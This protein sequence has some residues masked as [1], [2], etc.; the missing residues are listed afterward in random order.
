MTLIAQNIIGAWLEKAFQDHSF[1]L[2]GLKLEPLLEPLHN[3]PLNIIASCGPCAATKGRVVIDNIVFIEA[4]SERSRRECSD[5]F[6]ARIR[7]AAGL[8]LHRDHFV[9]F[10]G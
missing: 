3:D 9:G 5:E 4:R 1:F 6:H 10:G 8:L 2:A 7:M